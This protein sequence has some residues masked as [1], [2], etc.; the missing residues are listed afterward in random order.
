MNHSGMDATTADPHAGHHMGGHENMDH[1]NHIQDN[2]SP[3]GDHLQHSYDHAG[4][5]VSLLWSVCINTRY[6]IITGNSCILTVS[7]PL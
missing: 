4:M 5:M 1:T 6:N 3:H 7:C 2:G